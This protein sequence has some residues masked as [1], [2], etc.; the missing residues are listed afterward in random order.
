MKHTITICYFGTY[1]K[2]YTSNKM[3]LKGLSENDI[4]VVEV[5]AHIAVTNL[6][7]ENE[8]TWVQILRR[9]LG[10]YRIFTEITKNYKEFKKT[11]VIY[12]GYPG[13]VDVFLAFILAKLYGKKLIFNPLLIVYNGFVYEQGIL[14]E[15][16]I[17]AKTIKF[18]ESL[19]Y[20]MCDIVFADTPFQKVHLEKDFSVPAKKLRVLPIGADDKGYEFSPYE[21]TGKKI[22]V[23]YYGLYSPIHGVEHIIECARLLRNDKNIIFTFIGQGNTYEKNKKRSDELKLPNVV[24]HYNVPVETHLPIMQKA[25]IFLGFL[26]KHPTVDRVIPNKVYQ[27]LALGRV[28]LTADAPVTRSMFKHNENMYLVK[29]ADPKALKEAILELKND[30]DLRSKI[31]KNGYQLYREKF[32]PKAV[33]KQLVNFIEE[34]V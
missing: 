7:T 23:V 31:A 21:N 8:M 11:N 27:G 22:S 29:P 25:D 16:S 28:V 20:R 19:V 32:N 1:D 3:I 2:N 26:Q 5:N 9:I 30:P 18:T 33:G 15:N 13:H 24:F 4:R 17:L 10:K 34:I 6:T 14:K 12:V